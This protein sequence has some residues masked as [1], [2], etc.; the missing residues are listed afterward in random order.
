MIPARGKCGSEYLD[1]ETI[2]GFGPVLREVYLAVLQNRARTAIDT[3]APQYISQRKQSVCS[4]S[5]RAICLACAQAMGIRVLTSY[6][7][8]LSSVTTPRSDSQSWIG[9]GPCPMKVGFYKRT[10]ERKRSR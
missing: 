5:A 10:T 3:L 2:T 1:E 8:W 4:G 6:V 9:F 7:I